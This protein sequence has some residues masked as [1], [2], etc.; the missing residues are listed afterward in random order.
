MVIF[1]QALIWEAHIL[2]NLSSTLC[3]WARKALFACLILYLAFVIPAGA[4]YGFGVTEIDTQKFPIEAFGDYL[5]YN[6]KE[7]RVVI[8]GN[9][10]VKYRDMII[11]ADTIQANTKSEDIFAHGSVDFWR[12]YDQTKGD[13]MVYNMKT[14]KGWM[15]DATIRRNRNF[16]S[17]KEVY[18]SP[19]YS[20]A[21]DVMQTTCGNTDHPHYRITSNKIEIVPGHS[22]T[23][24]GLKLRWKEKII[25]RRGYDRSDLFRSDRFFTTRQGFSQI[26]GVY[27]KLMTDLEV[28]TGLK[29]RFSYDYFSRR[30]TGVGF[31]GN[32]S[33][34]DMSN[35][36]FSLYTL[37]ETLRNR[38]N[39]Q[40]NLT[41]NHRFARGDSLFTSMYYTGDR[42]G[43]QAENQD[44]NVQVNLTPVLQFMNMNITANKFYD[45]D[46]D[47]Y[48]LDDGYQVLNRVPEINFSFPGYPLPL[49]PVTLNLSGMYGRYEE[50]ALKGTRSTHKTDLRS[51]FTIPTVYVNRR[52][53][54]TPNYS[55]QKSMYSG[56]AEREAST[57]MVRANH[58]FSKVTSFEFNYNLSKQK[59]KT[60]FRFDS[61]TSTDIISS[62]LRISENTW[63]LNPLNFS[64]NRVTRRLGQ[65]YQDYSRRSRPD[66]YRNWEFFL[67]QDYIPKNVS[68]S[69]VSFSDLSMGNLNMRYRLSG[70]LWSFDTSINIPHTHRRVTN[71]SMNYRATIRPLWE[72]N[73]NSHYNHLTKKFSP[74]TLG[75]VRDLHCWEARVEYNHERQEFW[76]EFY[77]KAYPDDGGRFRYGADT[78]R[79]EVKLAAIDQMTQRYEGLR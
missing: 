65:V 3:S 52:F 78:K 21:H 41:H 49:L 10:Y 67:R 27:L 61:V 47:N 42:T 8:K 59:G 17:A 56:G 40:V 12:E 15:R 68:F 60:P 51:G 50:G 11:S 66:S 34:S 64:Y 9:A 22:M 7:E 26:D 24:E 63:T 45:L 31:T 29:G 32:W 44:L 5:E 6:T 18:V 19:A 62:R 23:I 33:T 14:G 54:F 70:Y 46:G 71:T 36:T 48:T 53:E 43:A 37:G 79:L 69:R 20:V 39:T 35:G 1:Q 30:G 75:L 72:V 58:K 55:F 2:Y 73:V 28:T 38:R 77:L 25:Y 57:I 74:L 13:F 16:F 4:A 76:I